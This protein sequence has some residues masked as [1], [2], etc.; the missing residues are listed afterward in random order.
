MTLKR[1]KELVGDSIPTRRNL[2]DRMIK[3]Q[4]WADKNIQD[5][6]ADCDRLGKI[7]I[8]L[9]KDEVPLRVACPVFNRDCNRGKTFLS[10]IKQIAEDSIPSA[11]PPRYRKNLTQYDETEAIRGVREWN[12]LGVMYIH[13][14]TG[15]GKSF[16]AA[17]W[18]FNR[19]MQRLEKEWEEPYRWREITAYE[20]RWFTAF[21]IC[22]DRAN[23]YEARNTPMLI[24]DDLGCE[25]DSPTNKAIINDL[26]AYRYSYGVPTIITSNLTPQEM[27]SRYKDRLY[28]RIIQTGK[29][30]DAGRYN[31]RLE[32]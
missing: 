27:S 8:Q 17:W 15:T 26:I 20:M 19:I 3:L 21:D 13:G 28:E 1:M 4:L 5:C 12:G 10:E 29:V 30:V 6:Q 24:I 32:I 23:M 9:E 7:S 16:A 22:L 14:L 25:T 2:I 31:K 18:P 11:I